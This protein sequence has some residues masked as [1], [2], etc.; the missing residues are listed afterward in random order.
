M[1][2]PDANII[3]EV[4]WANPINRAKI[5]RKMLLHCNANIYFNDTDLEPKTS[6]DEMSFVAISWVLNT[7]M[8]L[9]IVV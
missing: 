3:L 1:H 4:T 6:I 9:R 2:Q 5:V 7:N 8:I